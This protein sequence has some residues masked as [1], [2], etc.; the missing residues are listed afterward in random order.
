MIWEYFQPSS[1]EVALKSQ[2]PSSVSRVVNSLCKS[3][4]VVSGR[5]RP[6]SIQRLRACSVLH[7]DDE[8]SNR[9]HASPWKIT[10]VSA[11]SAKQNVDQEA[12]IVHLPPIV[13]KEMAAD[14]GKLTPPK[15]WY[16]GDSPNSRRPSIDSTVSTAASESDPNFLNL[17]VLESG[18]L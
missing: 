12:Q 1:A 16:D 9:D 7:V 17:A 18:E 13:P 10:V 4:C 6:S 14:F 5:I 8:L 2:R 15:L 11:S 3:A